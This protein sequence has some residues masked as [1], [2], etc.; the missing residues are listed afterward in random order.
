M[1]TV[2]TN[3]NGELFLIDPEAF[4]IACVIGKHNCKNTLDANADRIEYF[5][6]RIVEIGRGVCQLPRR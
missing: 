5:R 2:R 3:E 4:A 6:Q 1:A